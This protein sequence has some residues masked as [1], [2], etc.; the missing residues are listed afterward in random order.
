MKK[1]IGVL[2]FVMCG[3]QSAQAAVVNVD[4]LEVTY[5]HVN[6]LF[7]GGGETLPTTDEELLEEYMPIVM[8]GNRYVY[9]APMN[10]N[11]NGM[12]PAAGSIAGG[13]V[14]TA[15]LDTDTNALTID[16][17]SLFANVGDTDQN[18]G[19]IA[20]GFLNP[21]TGAFLA[22]WTTVLT[23]GPGAVGNAMTFTI[24]GYGYASA[25]PVPASIWLL[26]SGLIG[27]VAVARKKVV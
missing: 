13:P 11:P 4:S 25:V 3:F 24:G 20:T 23:Q 6:A 17:S 21:Q 12:G 27:L 10:M 26:G 16:M 7:L 14:P 15:T 19:G 2:V 1:I 22:S 5:L 18:V 8:S 9:T